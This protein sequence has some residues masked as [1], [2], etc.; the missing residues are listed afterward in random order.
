MVQ[1]RVTL[2]TS[3][4]R[5]IRPFTVWNVPLGGDHLS[6]ATFQGMVQ[7]EVT[8]EGGWGRR[9]RGLFVGFR[10]AKGDFTRTPAHVTRE[11]R[12]L[13]RARTSAPGADSAA[14]D[15]KDSGVDSS[16]NGNP[17]RERLRANQ[18]A[19]NS[20]GRAVFKKGIDLMRRP[21]RSSNLTTRKCS[22]T[23]GS[24][25]GKARVSWRSV[26]RASPAESED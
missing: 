4:R 22:V 15:I 1:S 23:N 13:N 19:R 18:S 2:C 3:T 12:N 20:S 26:E 17:S 21:F 9:P 24:D 5:P 6:H 8:V 25:M 10:S 16:T 7:E 14:C 11:T